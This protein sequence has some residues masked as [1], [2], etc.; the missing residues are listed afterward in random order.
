MREADKKLAAVGGCARFRMEDGCIIGPREEV[1]RIL[2]DFAKGI[3]ESK[4][5]QLV[6]RKC[7]MYSLDKR[8]WKDCKERNVIPQE[9]THKEEGIYVTENRDF[10]RGII[11]FNVPIGEPE[12]VE[13][14]LRDKAVEVVKVTRTYMED[15]EDEYPQELWTILQYSLQHRITYW[16]RTYTPEET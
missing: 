16:L 6:A 7:K 10:L 12:Y 3:E 2:A 8:A 15:R 1:F 9:L 14:V 11:V 13:A 5:C 4:G